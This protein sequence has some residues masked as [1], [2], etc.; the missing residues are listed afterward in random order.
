MSIKNKMILGLV[1]TTILSAP[2]LAA[3][4]KKE[5]TKLVG[6]NVTETEGAEIITG[7][8]MGIFKKMDANGDNLLSYKEYSRFAKIED[9]YSAYLRMDQDSDKAVTFLEYSGFNNTGKGS[10]QFESE[11]HGKTTVK[12][13]NL[14]TRIIEPTTKTY[15]KPVEPEIVAIEP[16]AE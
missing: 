5:V 11:L 6:Y 10:T 16:A 13:T 7:P 4:G 15:Y 9:K 14:K 1:L 3:D 8:K 2:A 12:G